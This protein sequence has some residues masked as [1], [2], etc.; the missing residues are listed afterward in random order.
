VINHP[1]IRAVT[2]TGSERAGMAVA[3]AAGK[4]LKKTV[5]ELGG[6]D[7]FI[8]LADADVEAVAKTAASARCINSGQS[9]IAAKR[10]IVDQAVV[11]RF[12]ATMTEAMAAMVVGDPLD[13]LTQVGP[14]A[15]LDLLEE[16]DK[17]VQA[18]VKAG[19]RLLCGGRRADRRGYFYEPTVLADVRPG[20]E[21]FDEET[22]GPVGAITSFATVAEAIKLA[23]QSRYGLGASVWTSEPDHAVE[24]AP[25]IDAGCVFINGIVKSDARLPFGGVKSSGYG[26]EL[27]DFGLMEF[28][29]IKT[30]WV[31]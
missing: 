3:S 26:R 23:N 22:F 8:V 25:Q 5:L 12:E 1:A 30:V 20:M 24:I 2:L 6:S 13:P 9:C 14:M 31:G 21:A 28:V 18:S 7:P 10:F 4:A 15:R 27:A 17:Q 11:S 16:L 19:A 29:N